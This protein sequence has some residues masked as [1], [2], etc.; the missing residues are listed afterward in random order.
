MED[1]LELLIKTKLFEKYYGIDL[2]SYTK[3][4]FRLKTIT[5][6]EN[7]F[8]RFYW[9]NLSSDDT[10][11]LSNHEHFKGIYLDETT[12]NVTV[13]KFGYHYDDSYKGVDSPIEEEFNEICKKTK[14]FIE[15]LNITDI[16]NS[17]KKA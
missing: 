12:D 6:C 4:P 7:I 16:S 17:V 11:E 5:F 10:F 2:S 9:L 14:D 15:S 1:K 3:W 13:V 8:I